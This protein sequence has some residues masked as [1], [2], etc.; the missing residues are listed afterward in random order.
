[1]QF[2]ILKQTFQQKKQRY[3]YFFGYLDKGNKTAITISS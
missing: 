2:Y 3:Q 1:M